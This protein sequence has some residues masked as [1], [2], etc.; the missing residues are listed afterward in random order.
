MCRS[1]KKNR[2]RRNNGWHSSGTGTGKR[3][4]TT[5]KGKEAL[6]F[7]TKGLRQIA[8]DVW[9]NNGQSAGARKS[10]AGN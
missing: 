4:E 10:T 3:K 2:R 9:R 1:R 8:Q 6:S 5:A 7:V